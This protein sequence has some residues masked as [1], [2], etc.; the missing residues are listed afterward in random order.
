MQSCLSDIYAI[1]IIARKRPRNGVHGVAGQA[2]ERDR[3]HVGEDLGH[4]GVAV[5]LAQVLDR[6]RIELVELFRVVLGEQDRRGLGRVLGLQRLE[7]LAEDLVDL[8]QR[9]AVGHRPVAVAPL[10][11]AAVGDRD[12]AEHDLLAQ[13]SGGLRPDQRREEDGD[14]GHDVGDGPEDV[15]GG[16]RALHLPGG[17]GRA[18]A[19]SS[20]SG[21]RSAIVA[22]I[23]LRPAGAGLVCFRSPGRS[24]GRPCSRRR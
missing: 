1:I 12:H 2:A 22:A 11:V 4:L 19:P 3:A 18:I 6:F 24:S 23:R 14:R 8:F 21:V 7:L 17:L 9:H 20:V 15:A 10:A 5:V 16:E 13:R